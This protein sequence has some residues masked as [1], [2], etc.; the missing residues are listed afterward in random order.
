MPKHRL[1]RLLGS[2]AIAVSIVS[3]SARGELATWDQAQVAQLTTELVTATDALH[4]TF[5][6]QPDPGVGSMQSNAYLRLKQWIRMLEA[7]SRALAESTAKG[8]AREETLAMYDNV[9]QLARSARE[10]A[11]KA[12]ISKEVSERA[13]AVRAVLNRLGPY[14]D[15]D[16]QT[17]VPSRNLEPSAPR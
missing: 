8:E 1:V 12:F 2:L 6:K 13:A 5:L 16:F 15:P 10:D 3:A 14:Y 17:L 11:G 4:E 9:M 7:Q